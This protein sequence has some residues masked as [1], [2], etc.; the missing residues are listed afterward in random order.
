VIIRCRKW[1]RFCQLFSLDRFTL[2]WLSVESWIHRSFYSYVQNARFW[3]LHW[4]LNIG[5]SVLFTGS[6]AFRFMSF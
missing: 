5:S 3:K 1:I 4:K 6:C 2:F